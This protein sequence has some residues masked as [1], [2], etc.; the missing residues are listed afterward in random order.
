MPQA[1]MPGPSLLQ[2]GVSQFERHMLGQL[3]EVPGRESASR[4]GDGLGERGGG[5][6]IG[7]RDLSGGK[8]LVG[9]SA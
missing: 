3:A 1:T 7:Q 6:L 8:T 2:Y 9:F 5:T 4:A